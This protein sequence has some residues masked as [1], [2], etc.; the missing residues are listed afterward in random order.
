MHDKLLN[1]KSIKNDVE[2]RSPSWV[3]FGAILKIFWEPE[4]FQNRSRNGFGRVLDEDSISKL[5]KGGA[6]STESRQTERFCGGRETGRGHM[7][8]H[9]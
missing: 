9:A 8:S 3:D 1:E 5:K 2:Y 7:A 4:S 6:K